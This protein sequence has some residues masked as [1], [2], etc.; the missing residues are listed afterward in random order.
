MCMMGPFTAGIEFKGLMFIL[1]SNAFQA[2]CL[3]LWTL[4]TK[5]PANGRGNQRLITVASHLP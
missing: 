2:H 3:L 1:N 4:Y 5:H